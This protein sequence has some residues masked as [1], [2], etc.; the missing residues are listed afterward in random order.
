MERRIAPV[1]AEVLA[2]DVVHASANFFELGGH[3]LLAGR[4]A[5]RVHQVAGVSCDLGDIFTHPTLAELARLV[6]DR[7]GSA[8]PA[9]DS[10]AE[11]AIPLAPLTDAERALLDR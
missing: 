5:T 10:A 6:A 3:S 4:L 7:A 11:Q 2:L 1:W 8:E 9:T